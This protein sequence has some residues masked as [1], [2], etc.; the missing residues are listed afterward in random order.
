MEVFGADFGAWRGAIA[1]Y[2]IPNA[3]TVAWRDTLPIR[4]GW[5]RGLGMLA[6]MFAIESFMDEL[7]HTAGIDPLQFRLAHVPTNERGPRLKAALEKV[8]AMS[9]WNTPAPAGHARGIAC[10][11]DSGTVVAHVAEVAINNGAIQVTRFWSVVDP[12]LVIN[13]DGVLAQTQGSIVM[14]ISSTLIEELTI[15]DSQFSASNFDGYPLITLKDVPE[16]EVAIL[17]S[18]DTPHGMGEPAIGPVAAAVANAVF[19]LNGQRLRR[20][21]LKLTA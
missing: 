9:S 17:S 3:R 12:G 2:N 10:G 19:A 16:V 11:F 14:G 5:W 21:P 18:G 7:A 1:P 8:A 15:K 13:P 6:N 4:T 20:L